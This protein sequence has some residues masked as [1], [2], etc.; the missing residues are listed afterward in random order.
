MNL[1]LPLYR[2]AGIIILLISTFCI[3]QK[4]NAQCTTPVSVFP[5][6]EGFEITN[7]GW[8]A[9]G[10]GSDR[11]WGTPSKPV[12]TGAATGTK[13]WIIG[14]LTGS[15]YTNGEASWLQSPCFDFTGLQYPFIS[16]NVFWEMEQRF[17]G[18]GFQFSTNLGATWTNV[19]SV[20]EPASCLN[21]NWFN[22]SPITYLNG[23][24][25]VRD[26]WSGNIET[27]AGSCLGGNG[28][29]GW[30]NATHAMAQPGRYTQ[31]NF[32]VYIWR[33]YT[34]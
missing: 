3:S 5:Y 32:P 30:K 6:T 33:R 26:G 27:T 34:M 10:T 28:S 11:A 16:F 8:T 9:G 12:I 4:S 24:A 15:S 1:R 17:D 7:G 22:F 18:A 19:G 31:C 13:C 20:S 14:G 29:G 23:L 25:T 2:T 21:T